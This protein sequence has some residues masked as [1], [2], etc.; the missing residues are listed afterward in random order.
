M[1]AK[2]MVSER[3]ALAMRDGTLVCACGMEMAV[4][5]CGC[6]VGMN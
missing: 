6:M 5:R 4:K 2:L 3:D 1:G